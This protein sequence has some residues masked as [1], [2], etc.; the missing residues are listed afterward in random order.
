MVITTDEISETM[1][2]VAEAMVGRAKISEYWDRVRDE[3]RPA[4]PA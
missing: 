3:P 4:G 1:M 2:G